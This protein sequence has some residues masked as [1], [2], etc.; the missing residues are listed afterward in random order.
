MKQ[1]LF[2]LIIVLSVNFSL[3]AQNT[4]QFFIDN[5]PRDANNYVQKYMDPYFKAFSNNMNSGWYQTAKPHNLGKFNIN[6]SVSGS[7][8]PQA[9]KSFDLNSL[10]LQSV[11]IKN[12]QSSITPTVAGKDEDGPILEVFIKN[13]NLPFPGGEYVVTDFNAVQGLNVGTV[14]TPILQAAVGVGLGTEVMLRILP[15]V[16][17]DDKKGKVSLFGFGLKHSLNQYFPNE[18]D[19]PVDL[20][21]M[22]AFSR[23]NSEYKLGLKPE[24]N[25]PQR[26]GSAPDYSSQLLEF[27]SNNYTVAAIISKKISVITLYGGL[28]YNGGITT[29]K[30]KGIYPVTIIEDNIA[31]SQFA[32]EVI[33]NFTDPT[34][35]ETDGANGAKV[36]AGFRLKLAAFTLHADYSYANYSTLNA[37][38]GIAIGE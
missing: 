32:Q 2:I 30:L 10:N 11:R 9:D 5:A 35:L 34:N 14:P 15:T 4:S 23:F 38:L 24:A 19:L 6:F 17:F 16:R 20:A 28:G 33:I 3:K 18:D 1:I 25:R 36:T 7:F 13:P 22:G 37:G 21:V 26:N 29:A 27:N 8:V 12:G 31:S